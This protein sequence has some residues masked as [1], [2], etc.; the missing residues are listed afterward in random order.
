MKQTI[1]LVA[2]VLP[3]LFFK[4]SLGGGAIVQKKSGPTI[5]SRKVDH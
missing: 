4:G 2:P 3:G 1:Q 5:G